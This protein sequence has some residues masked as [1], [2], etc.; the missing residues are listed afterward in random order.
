VLKKGIPNE[1]VMFNEFNYTQSKIFTL[2]F[3]SYSYCMAFY[4][5]RQNSEDRLNEGSK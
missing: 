4:S 1:I 2:M 3:T 5:L